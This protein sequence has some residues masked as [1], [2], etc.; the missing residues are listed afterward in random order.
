MGSPLESTN[1]P[2]WITWDI[3]HFSPRRKSARQRRQTLV[4]IS[5]VNSEVVDELLKEAK[6]LL[7]ADREKDANKLINIAEKV[8]NNNR[9]FQN[10]VGDILSNTD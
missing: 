7:K 2:A 1:K 9:K 8:V 4:E 5:L 10:M 6:L 3:E